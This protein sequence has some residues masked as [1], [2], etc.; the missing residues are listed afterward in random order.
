MKY[1]LTTLKGLKRRIDIQLDPT[2]VQ[3]TFDENYQKA[4]KKASIPGYRKGKA[5]MSQVRQFYTDK[6]IKDTVLSLINEFYPKALKEANI[7]PVFEPDVQFKS[8]LK[9]N[10]AFSF[11]VTVEVRPDVNVDI[12]FK[13]SL[14]PVS[15]EV[16]EKEVDQM[17]ENFRNVDPQYTS[18][19]EV[20][21]LQWGDSAKVEIK[22]ARTNEKKTL[23]IEITKELADPI[24]LKL[25]EALVGLFPGDKKDLPMH[26]MLPKVQKHYDKIKGKV[27]EKSATLSLHVLKI[28]KKILRELNDSLAQVIGYKDIA[29]MRAD[30]QSVIEEKKHADLKAS[31]QKEI[32]H[33]LMK[34]YPVEL[35][36]KL[37]SEQ[38]QTLIDY[39]G[40]EM[41]IS[42]MTDSF[43]QEQIQKQEKRFEE[44]A[45]LMLHS[46]YLVANLSKK[47]KFTVSDSEIQLYSKKM[48][49]ENPQNPED[50]EQVKHLILREKVVDHLIKKALSK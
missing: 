27:K 47:L 48:E 16:T 4:R 43:I 14:S 28:Q 30:I 39:W 15:I 37:L 6:V 49:K 20:R 19:E 33:Q 5:P 13:P 38:K 35:P 12:D 44:E 9:E 11:S 18:L 45:R 22:N 46:D 26:L 10:Q 50:R 24:G 34:K 40:E 21:A 36:E 29:D 42:G 17:M 23:S 7:Q 1:E 31:R 3:K 2:E 41:K 8:L 32:L 25:A